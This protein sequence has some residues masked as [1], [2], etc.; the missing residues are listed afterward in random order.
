M[1]RPRGNVGGLKYMLFQKKGACV[2]FGGGGAS[3]HVK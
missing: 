2:N 1:N 3:D